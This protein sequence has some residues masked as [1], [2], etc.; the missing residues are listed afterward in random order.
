MCVCTYHMYLFNKMCNGRKGYNKV[1]VLQLDAIQTYT[2]DNQDELHTH[3]HTNK[4]IQE[5]HTYTSDTQKMPER[6][7]LNRLL[8]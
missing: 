3:A 6:L 4:H 5:K 8:K 1:F 2:K 7:I